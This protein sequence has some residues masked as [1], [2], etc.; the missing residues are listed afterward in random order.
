MIGESLGGV[1][2]ASENAQNSRG[3]ME[4]MQGETMKESSWVQMNQRISRERRNVEAG[5]QKESNIVR[6]TLLNGSAWSTE[7]FLRR[8]KGTFDIFFGVEHRMRNEEMEEQ[9]NK[10]AKQ[11]WRFAGRLSKDHRRESKQ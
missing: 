3:Q 9:F 5:K 4:G 10:E 1:H 7:K 11:G 6:C 8:Y 2:A